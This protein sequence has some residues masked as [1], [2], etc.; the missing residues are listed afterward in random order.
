MPLEPVRGGGALAGCMLRASTSTQ[1][2]PMRVHVFGD[3]SGNCNGLS[4]WKRQG[5]L[6]SKRNDGQTRHDFVVAVICHLMPVAARKSV[7]RFRFG[8][9]FG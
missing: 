1:G 8:L 6:Y 2:M 4:R 9:R 5:N 7:G 3:R